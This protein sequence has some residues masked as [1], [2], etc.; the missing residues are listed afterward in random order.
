MSIASKGTLFGIGA[1]LWLAA[2]VLAV[3]LVYELN[4]P[5]HAIGSAAAFPPSA[6]AVLAVG[7]LALASILAGWGYRFLVRSR[8]G[9]AHVRRHA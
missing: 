8:L 4:R 3:S 1:G 7:W 2:S 5:L 9:H 6:A